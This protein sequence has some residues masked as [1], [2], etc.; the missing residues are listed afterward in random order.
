M[1][2]AA[3]IVDDGVFEIYDSF[4][5]ARRYLVS[6]IN[7]ILNEFGEAHHVQK[8]DIIIVR[9]PWTSCPPSC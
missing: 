8:E 7:W 1:K 6:N 5:E 4:A 9:G 3:L 2:Q